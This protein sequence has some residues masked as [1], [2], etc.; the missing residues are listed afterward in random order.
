MVGLTP[1]WQE[2]IAAPAGL[3]PVPAQAVVWGAGANATGVS[4][5]V[6]ASKLELLTHQIEKTADRMGIT[7]EE[8]RDLVL[9]RKAYAGKI[10]PTLLFAM[11]AGGG[12]GAFSLPFLMGGEN[13]SE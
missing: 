2:K 7:P 10:D 6:G 12:L 4:S 3:E 5:P 11:G 13:E 8:A 1:W 9:R